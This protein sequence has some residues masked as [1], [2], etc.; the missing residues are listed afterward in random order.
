MRGAWFDL[1]F[2][3]GCA[4]ALAAAGA[5]VSGCSSDPGGPTAPTAPTSPGMWSS[6]TSGLPSWFSSAPPPPARPGTPAAAAPTI[7]VDEDCPVVQVRTGAATLAI[8]LRAEQPS[9]QDL[10]YQL[11]FTDTARQCA[12]VGTDLRMRVGVQGRVVIGPAGAPTQVEVPLRYAVVREGVAP[13][14]IT[15]KF[16]RFPVPMGPGATNVLFTDIE[17]DLTFPI[18][19]QKEIEAYVV[20]VGFDDLG[21][22]D[23]RPAP[24]KSAPR[25]Q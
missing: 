6:V 10:R 5:L 24:K 25:A 3:W 17:E 11:S 16:R 15:T 9:P 13:R 22:R 23:R 18:P 20:Y 2:R 8:A 12:I 14:T 1:Q 21:D 19:S 4:A 7:R